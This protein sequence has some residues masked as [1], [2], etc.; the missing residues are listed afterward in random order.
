V[1]KYRHLNPASPYLHEDLAFDL[2]RGLAHLSPHVWDQR[3]CDSVLFFGVA[4]IAPASVEHESLAAYTVRA[5]SSVPAD[6]CQDALHDRATRL[7]PFSPSLRAAASFEALE[8]G[9]P[10]PPHVGGTLVQ[11]LTH[12]GFLAATVG[13]REDL[14][15]VAAMALD[16][17]WDVPGGWREKALI[18]LNMVINEKKALVAVTHDEYRAIKLKYGERVEHIH[19]MTLGSVKTLADGTPGRLKVRTVVTDVAKNSTFTGETYSGAVD[20]SSIRFLLAATLGRPGLKRYILDVKGA[21][22]QGTVPSPEDGGR[23]IFVFAPKGWAA[24]GFP[25]VDSEGRKVR[26]QVVR[27]VPGRQD[28]GRIWQSRYDKFM[29]S[30]AFTQSIVDRRV[31]YRRLPNDKLFVVGVYVDDNWCIC[32]DE[33]A[34]DVFHAAWKREFD[35]SD[36]VVQ[37]ADDFCGIL[38]GLAL[39]RCHFI[40]QEAFAV[41]ARDDYALPVPKPCCNADAPRL[42]CA[43]ARSR[44]TRARGAYPESAC[45]RWPR[46]VHRARDSSRRFVRRCERLS[47]HC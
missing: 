22:Y 34:W 46:L 12:E 32:D 2:S 31:F 45:Y 1:G 17:L 44:R 25:E 10:S 21:Y 3:A 19:V 43:Y 35:E 40:Q 47:A 15:T 30:Q 8:G 18:E 27:N 33:A 29:L 16:P 6:F 24:L 13:L 38:T 14:K 4:G 37:A 23:I 26:Y 28:A 41:A 5:A 9:S 20:D 11:E 7:A 36:N 42:P 39:R